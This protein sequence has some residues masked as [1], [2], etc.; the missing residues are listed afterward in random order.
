MATAEQP[1]SKRLKSGA[2]IIGNSY[3]TTHAL[4]SEAKERIDSYGVGTTPVFTCGTMDELSGHECFFKCEAMQK[5]GSF[6]ARGATNACAML[7]KGQPVVTHSSGNHAQ[8]IAYAAK[9]TGREA[10]IIMPDNAPMPKREGTAGYGAEIRLCEPTNEARAATAEAAVEEKGAAFVHPSENPNVIAGQGTVA[11]EFIQ[12]VKELQQGATEG[13]CSEEGEGAEAPFDLLVVPLGGGGLI[14]GCTICTKSL[15]PDV[16]VVGAEPLQV[17]DAYRSKMAGEM[18]KNEKGSTSV[19][20]GLKTNLGPNTWPVVRDLVDHVMLVA[21]EDI[22]SSTKLVWS[23]MKVQIEPSA[24][25][26][27]AV[28]MSE[29][30]RELAA[31]TVEGKGRSARVGVILCGGNADPIK[32]APALA[33]APALPKGALSKA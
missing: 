3:V 10:T 1:P 20:D 2:D 17:N 8:A 19:A 26:G 29:E 11:L 4:I 31:R 21:E 15:H 16:V 14:S 5:T 30:F 6:K 28:A 24:G 25:V 12:Q 32:L 9:A 22:L 13:S 27:V 18:L 23:R 7:D 33:A